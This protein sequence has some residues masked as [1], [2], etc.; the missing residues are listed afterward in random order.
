MNRT[1]RV[2]LGVL[3]AVLV[4]IG[5][6]AA[7]NAGFDA[8]AVTAAAADNGGM[9]IERGRGWHGGFG[10]FPF[11]PFFWIFPLLFIFLLVGA[12]RRPWRDG[13][14]FGPPSVEMEKRLEE[15]HRKA[16]EQT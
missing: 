7:Y 10:F 13:P 11:F 14:G 5:F 1:S 4:G 8:G 3:I 12:F 2:L 15:W 16:H 6:Y 9:M